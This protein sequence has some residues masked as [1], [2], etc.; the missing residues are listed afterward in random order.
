MPIETAIQEETD[1]GSVPRKIP[2]Y[3]RETARDQLDMSVED[4]A[5]LI[6]AKASLITLFEQSGCV[7]AW[8][9]CMRLESMFDDE[10]GEQEPG[11]AVFERLVAALNP[12][13]KEEEELLRSTRSSLK[14]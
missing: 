13:A 4:L 2:E 1:R 5:D 8:A 6:D 14:L 12:S 3:D 10:M 11:D 9:D 7:R